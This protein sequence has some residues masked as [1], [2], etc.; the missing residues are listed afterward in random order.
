MSFLMNYVSR[1]RECHEWND[2]ALHDSFKAGGGGG[3][4]GIVSYVI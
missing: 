1:V 3:K 4:G 2:S